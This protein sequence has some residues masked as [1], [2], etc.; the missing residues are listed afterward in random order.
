MIPALIALAFFATSAHAD[1]VP[2]FPAAS[3][4]VKTIRVESG[5]V[6]FVAGWEGEPGY[7]V[8]R[9]DKV[10]QRWTVYPSSHNLEGLPRWNSSAD[11]AQV[12]PKDLAAVARGTAL[13]PVHGDKYDWYGSAEFDDDNGTFGAGIFQYDKKTSSWKRI[14]RLNSGLPGDA[15]FS[16]ALDGDILW[17][18]TDQ[19]IARWNL[20]TDKWSY[21]GVR[22]VETTADDAK[23]TLGE[24]SLNNPVDYPTFATATRGQRFTLIGNR[25]NYKI[26]I[27]TAVEVWTKIDVSKAA[28]V[29][30]SAAS[31]FA[32]P[33][34]TSPALGSVASLC[35]GAGPGFSKVTLESNGWYLVTLNSAWLTATE[36]KAIV[37]EVPPEWIK[38]Q[39]GVGNESHQ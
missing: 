4:I 11:P 15:V 22:E 19:G 36:A 1:Y 25:W 17:V 23:L 34:D 27:S 12:L 21:F 39:I 29:R 16:L 18:G 2:I 3:F 26:E 30:Y 5:A 7:G 6:W 28:N 31:F 10:S 9:L 14:T 8:F 24:P 37:S 13:T 33:S 32:L 35:E 20:S 38:H